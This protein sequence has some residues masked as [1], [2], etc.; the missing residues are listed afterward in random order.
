[1]FNPIIF[2]V[3]H[4]HYVIKGKERAVGLWLASVS[5]SIFGMVVLGG[6]T[7]LTKSGLSMVRWEPHRILPPMSQE[8]WLAEFEEYKK[9]PEW[10]QVNSKTGMDVNGFKYIFFWEWAHRILG[11]SIGFTFFVPMVYFWARG[12]LKG[13][14]KFTLL[15]LF[16]LGGVQGAIGW[17]MVKSG[18]VDKNKTGEVDKTPRVSPYRLSVHAGF[19]YALYATTLWQTLNVLKRPQEAVANTFEK[20]GAINTYRSKL[21]RFGFTLFPLVLLTGFFTA[22]TCAGISCNTFPKVGEHWF[23]NSNH[24]FR[25]D[26][27]NAPAWW[28]NFTENKLICQVNHRTLAS[29]MTVWATAV[30]LGCLRIKPLHFGAKASIC[31]LV[32][33]LWSQLFIGV[34]V[35]WNSVP[36]WLAST[37]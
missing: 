28:R 4:E 10:I 30:G 33:A 24:F 31:F 7:R 25:S 5:A 12:Y 13:R 11:R 20:V 18:L 21:R 15:S 27:V 37:H 22:G 36:V 29:I 35:I 23:Y 14:L 9:S 19:A 26:D 32:A 34:N 17:W 3:K 8:Q 2:N 6:Y 16:L 1:M